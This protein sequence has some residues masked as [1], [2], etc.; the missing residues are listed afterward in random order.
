MD[1]QIGI[2]NRSVFGSVP[3]RKDF[4]QHGRDP[5]IGQI[6]G[7][8]RLLSERPEIGWRELTPA[9]RKRRV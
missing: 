5:D 6:A 9:E 2:E 4:A 7:N 1:D 3:V 8:L